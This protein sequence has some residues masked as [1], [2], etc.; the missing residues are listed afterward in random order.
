MSIKGEREGQ[1]SITHSGNFIIV[2]YLKVFVCVPNKIN[3]FRRQHLHSEGE[4]IDDM[5]IMIYNTRV[6]YNTEKLAT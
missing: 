6:H 4:N 5:K 1:E 2:D 3:V